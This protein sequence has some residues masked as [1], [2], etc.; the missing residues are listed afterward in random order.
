[1][2]PFE[3]S[4]LGNMKLTNRIGIP[5]MCTY[6]AAGDGIATLHHLAHYETLAKGRPAFIVQEATAVAQEGYISDSCLGIFTPRQREPLKSVVEMV[7]AY[8]VKFGI[9]LNHAGMKGKSAAHKVS[10]MDGDDVHALSEEELRR[11]IVNFEFAGKWAKE[12]GYDFVEIHAAHGYLINQFLSP[13]TNQRKDIYG[14]DRTL[15]LKEIITGVQST[16]EKDVI[17]RISAEEYEES[18]LHIED[19]KEIVEAIESCG[20]VAISVSSGGLNKKPIKTYPMYQIPYAKKVKQMTS[21]PVMG[22]GL[23]TREAEI[24]KVLA[25]EDCDYVLLGRKLLRDPYFILRWRDALGILNE[26]EI[27]ESMYRAL[28]QEHGG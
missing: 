15:L 1:M 16:F 14:E 25:D 17:V 21:L 4:K 24:E 10:A 3:T 5:A 11:I 2:K 27:G 22:V 13:L 12:L 26:D 19:M 18:G 23:I 28:H 7:H 20:A 8:D 6:M 9:Q